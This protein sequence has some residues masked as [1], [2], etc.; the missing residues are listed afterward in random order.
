MGSA[1]IAAVPKRVC[2]RGLLL[3]NLV[4]LGAWHTVLTPCPLQA[5]GHGGLSAL[6]GELEAERPHSYL[7]VLAYGAFPPRAIQKLAGSCPSTTTCFSV[8]EM[9][10]ATTLAISRSSPLQPWGKGGGNC[11]GGDHL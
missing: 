1:D 11:A 7:L 8:R 9:V 10:S 3:T 2:G 4:A 6:E 5:L